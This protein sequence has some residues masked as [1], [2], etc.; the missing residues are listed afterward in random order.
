MRTD[1]IRILRK[2]K[3]NAEIKVTPDKSITHRAVMLASISS[4]E[5]IIHNPLKSKDCYSTVN[6]LKSL[7]VKIVEDKNNFHIYGVN[8]EGLCSPKEVIDAG[9]SGTTVRLLCGII[10]GNEIEVKI[11]G[12]DSLSRRPMKRIIEPLRLMGVTIDAKED[13]YLPLVIRGTKNLKSITWENKIA[14]AQVKSCVLFAGMYAEGVTIYKEPI[15]SRDHTERMLQYL[16]VKLSIKDTV[17]SIRGKVKKIKPFEI[18]VPADP[19]SASYFIAMAVLLPNSSLVI[20]D[21][22]VN[23]TRMGFINVLLKMGAKIT[24]S[25]LRILY[26]EPVADIVVKSSKLKSIKIEPDD[27]PAMIDELPLLAVVA[28]QADGVTEIRGAGELRIKE[29]DRIKT[30]VSSL[31]HL[32]AKIIELEDGMIIMGNTTLCADSD[33][34]ELDSYNDHRIA[35]SLAVAGSICHNSF[36][37]TNAG[38]VDVSFPGFWDLYKSL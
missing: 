18:L 15:L 35:M 38:C 23:P 21:V 27:V 25:N 7:G 29:S 10:A 12:D 20:K 9:N 32:G 30:I 36:V 16:G 1:K 28:T 19:S 8:M 26:N 31:Q 14:S 13:N 4:G 2:S 17:F 37:I 34:L 6:A 5:C 11:I 33:N 3:I 22:C 24:L